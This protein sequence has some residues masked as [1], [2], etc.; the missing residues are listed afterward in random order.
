M[1]AT[2]RFF[3]CAHCRAQVI[4]CRRC[5]RGQIYCNGGCSQAA[6]RASL[7][8]AAQRYQRS[9]RGR[10]AYAERMRRYRSRQ[11]KVTHQGSVE[12]AADALLPLTLTTPARAPTPLAPQRLYLSIATSAVAHTRALSASDHC[13]VGSSVMFVRLIAQD[14]THDHWSRP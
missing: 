11:K 8:E 9:R 5:D 7:R 10:L 2:G 12:Q 13:V 1:P 14:T 3:V 4:V 6:R